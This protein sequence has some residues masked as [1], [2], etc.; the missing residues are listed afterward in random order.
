[1][2]SSV[3]ILITWLA[4]LNLLVILLINKKDLYQLLVRIVQVKVISD[5]VMTV[6]TL[7]I[8]EHTYHTTMYTSEMDVSVLVS[9]ILV[10]Q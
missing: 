10:T 3:G 2:I 9:P 7:V 1:M 5:L 8:M 4:F 6:I